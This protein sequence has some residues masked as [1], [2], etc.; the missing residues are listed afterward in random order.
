MD[1]RAIRAALIVACARGCRTTPPQPLGRPVPSR[2]TVARDAAVI[3]SA[4][5][6]TSLVATLADE[7]AETLPPE[8]RF[9][10][11]S[12]SVVAAVLAAAQTFLGFAKR[13]EQHVQAADCY[14]AI[15]RKIDA[16]GVPPPGSRRS[17]EDPR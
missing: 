12:L 4:I 7:K 13:S 10:I 2:E 16:F 6:G 11:A 15:Q 17:E 5:V 1:P 3:T 14:A 9:A 8:M